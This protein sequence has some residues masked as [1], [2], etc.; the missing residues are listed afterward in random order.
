MQED[1]RI[2]YCCSSPFSLLKPCSFPFTDTSHHSS[3]RRCIYFLGETFQKS[4]Y[5]LIVVLFLFDWLDYSELLMA[6]AGVFS[7]QFI[8][9]LIQCFQNGFR[10]SFSFGQLPKR[11]MLVYGMYSILDRSAAVVV[12]SMD[13]MM[14]GAIVG[15]DDVAFYTLAF[16][17]GSV[18]LIPQK[19]ISVIANPLVS[20]AIEK[21]DREHLQELY[22]KTSL[23]QLIVGGTVF[24]AVWA[25]VDEIM[26]LVPEKFQGGKWIILF[27][28]LS[29]LFTLASGVSGAMIIYSKWF[30]ANLIINSTLIGLTALTN[31]Y[32]ISPQ[33][34]G[35]GID[36][37]AIATAITFLLYFIIKVSFV[38]SRFK[39]HPFTGALFL[40]MLLL[41]G[42]SVGGY[43]VDLGMNPF[44]A[45]I[46]KSAIVCTVF[47]AIV[48]GF[49]LSPDINQW[50]GRLVKR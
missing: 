32:L 38:W 25:N 39:L 49:R 33:H 3:R 34:F 28:G 47:G 43:F 46:I 10:P 48:L 36:G 2:R 9:L 11:E 12:A 24:M 26:M 31:Y 30:R 20:K 16:Y 4:A 35:L 17:I 29:K 6:Y 19:S 50:V 41:G 15:L 5:L 1:C 22:T 8:I 21:N 40:V 18:T 13:I 44:V 45:I 42:L 37:A 23:N 7:L 27:V 14:I